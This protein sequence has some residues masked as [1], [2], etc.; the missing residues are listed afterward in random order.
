MRKEQ[1][2]TRGRKIQNVV[3]VVAYLKAESNKYHDASSKV[4]KHTNKFFHRIKAGN[5]NRS[6]PFECETIHG[7]QSM[8]QVKSISN[9]DP[10]F[11]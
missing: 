10:T 4:R 3:D 11:C 1:I 5:V 9:R 8:H 6:K 2:K 7:S